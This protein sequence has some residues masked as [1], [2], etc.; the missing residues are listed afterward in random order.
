MQ[1]FARI[2]ACGLLLC[3]SAAAFAQSAGG[4]SDEINLSWPPLQGFAQRL[5]RDGVLLQ[6]Q[7]RAEFAGN[8]AGGAKQGADYV[9]ELAFGAKFDMGKLAKIPGG[10]VNLLFTQRQGNNLAAR[11]INNS[12]SVQELYGGGQTFQLTEFTYDQALL[13]DQVDVKIGRT[14]LA[15]DF[16]KLKLY[17][18]FQ[19]NAV[20]GNPI[21]LF[22][23]TAATVYPVAS[24]GGR[25]K[26]REGHAYLQTGIYQDSSAED[27]QAHHGFDWALQGENG[28]LVPV[29]VGESFT[30]PGADVPDEYSAGVIFDRGRYH[31]PAY[32]RIDRAY[33]GSGGALAG[34]GRTAFY[35]Q[36]EQ[37]ALQPRPDKSRGLYLFASALFGLPDESQVANFTLDGGMVYRGLFPSRPRDDLGFMVSEI[38]YTSRTI[39]TAF[40]ERRSEGGSQYP[41][42]NLVMLELNY[43]AQVSPW[44]NVMPNF[45]F[46][47]NPDGNGGSLP[48][49]RAN[50][51]DAAVFGVQLQIVLP[52]L[53]GIPG[54]S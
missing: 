48:Y 5:D 40:T 10:T 39:E 24:W 4:N 46:I 49:P 51:P 15:G 1:S 41:A 53:L 50:L 23:D 13:Q 2:I 32:G 18:R 33:Q 30:T 37:M 43:A 35:V 17:C 38:H 25:I 21:T 54:K 26:I 6:G 11:T 31:F 28:F 27:P 52:K 19:S 42:P 36:G 14:E 29:E 8:P 20:C 47:I 45:Q 34:Y 16:F 22:Q 7:Y 9:G 12:V 3:C 44:L